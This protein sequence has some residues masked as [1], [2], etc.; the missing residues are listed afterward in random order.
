MSISQRGLATRNVHSAC[1]AVRRDSQCPA[2]DGEA[3]PGEMFSL[4][5]L[6]EVVVENGLLS[7]ATRVL[8]H[9]VQHADGVEH[10]HDYD[11][12][13]GVPVAVVGR[14]GGV[15]CRVRVVRSRPGD[16]HVPTEDEQQLLL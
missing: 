15:A 10:Q 2:V 3:A 6:R 16:G 5:V 7:L 1:I 13:E 4:H 9:Q 8:H 14:C 12:E 11:V